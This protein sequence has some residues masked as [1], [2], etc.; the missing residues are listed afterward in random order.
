VEREIVGQT[1]ALRE[2]AP[3]TEAHALADGD[4]VPQTLAEGVRVL[5]PHRVAVTD[6]LGEGDEERHLEGV[7]LPEALRDGDSVPVV[8][9]VGK[10]EGELQPLPVRDRVAEVHAV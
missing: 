3:V 9:A 8:H 2:G 1:V 10:R 6:I 5:E 4:T 7:G